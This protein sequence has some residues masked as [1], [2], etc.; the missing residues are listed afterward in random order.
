MR[1]FKI[2]P[3]LVVV[4]MLSFS[5]RLADFYSGMSSTS[6]SA[7]A[8]KSKS[9]AKAK[10]GGDDG[11]LEHVDDDYA[12]AEDKTSHGDEPGYEPAEEG[13]DHDKEDDNKMR[14]P[15]RWR[16]AADEDLSLTSIKIE[17]YEDLVARRKELDERSSQLQTREALLTAAEMELD[18]KYQELT[19]LRR[20]I[21]SLLEQQS[22]EEKARVA[23][24]VKIYEGMKAKE[25]AAIFDT[26]DIDILLLVL[27]NMSER[28]L[29]PIL[30]KMNPERAR[31]VTILL[32]EQKQLPSLPQ[33]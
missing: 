17:M 18:R 13:E 1:R 7:M 20:K 11:G 3:L 9:K 25:A 5:V 28:K 14:D 8:A 15:D 6:G 29:S 30:A 19:H 31:T 26:L 24:L 12:A 4:A 16:D 2:L 21:E 22:E 32:A 33:R 27:S 23:S 10:S